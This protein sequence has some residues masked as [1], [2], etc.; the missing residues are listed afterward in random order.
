MLDG[1]DLMHVQTPKT[2]TQKSLPKRRGHRFGEATGYRFP[3]FQLGMVDH[4]EV[5]PFVVEQ[6]IKKPLYHGS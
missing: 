4:S 6:C 2:G 5:L 3:G 1:I